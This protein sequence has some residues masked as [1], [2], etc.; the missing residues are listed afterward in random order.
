MSAFDSIRWVATAAIVSQLAFAQCGW[1]IQPGSYPGVEGTVR[2]SHLWDPDGSG[3]Q[4]GHLVIGGSL[5]FAGH[6]RVNGIAI[7]HEATRTWQPVGSAIPTASL[8]PQ[9]TVEALATMANGDLLVGGSFQTIDGVAVANVARFD[10]QAWTALGAGTGDAVYALTVLA[11]GNVVAGGE[12]SGAGTNAASGIAQWDGNSWS[13]LGAGLAWP[14]NQQEVRALAQLPNGDVIAGG[15]FTQAGAVPA[16]G[17]ARWDGNSWSG[18]GGGLNSA[19]LAIEVM[20]NGDMIVGGSF[21]SAGGVSARG[22]ARWDGTGWSALSTGLS[23]GGAVIGTVNGLATL[24]SGDLIAVGEFDTAGTAITPRSRVARWDGSQWAALGDGVPVGEVTTATVLAGGDLVIGGNFP[25]AGA[26][27]AISIARWDG[28]TWNA[29]SDGLNAAVHKLAVLPDGDLIAGGDFQM[30]GSGA[31]QRI[32]RWDGASWSPLGAGVDGRVNAIASLPNGDVVAGGYFQQAGSTSSDG[33]ARWDGSQWHSMLPGF[34]GGSVLG[35]LL[36]ANGQLVAVGSGQWGVRAWSGSNWPG[37]G[38][39]GGAGTVGQP[40]FYSVAELPN[41]DLVVGGNFSTVAGVAATCVARFDGSAWQPMG[42]GMSGM[43]ATVYC[44]AVAP[45]GSLVAGGSFTSAGGVPCDNIARWN[46]TSW[47]PIGN[48]L[49]G[50][51]VLDLDVLPN[52][53]V[54]ATGSL[55]AVGP[56]GAPRFARFNGNVWAMLAS[57]PFHT[58][59]IAR[60]PDGEIWLGG[61]RLNRL[62]PLCPATVADLGGGCVGG[63]GG[64]GLNQLVVTEP[65]WLGSTLRTRGSGL[66]SPSIAAIVYGFAPTFLPLASVLPQ[67]LAGC[68]LLATPDHVV[69]D[70]PVAGELDAA[71]TIPQS[72]ALVGVAVFEQ[73]V[74]FE[75]GPSSNLAAVSA[76]NALRLTVGSL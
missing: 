42:S 11:N 54:L 39:A 24:P 38:G 45:D 66:A 43:F 64:G 60:L 32:A 26:S 76:S 55:S 57:D 62:T 30:I 73:L 12:F 51:L 58:P 36:R 5:G 16:V 53:D 17:I 68:D 67:A 23:V 22:I 14:G 59:Q 49:P 44:F 52:G 34:L 50:A 46:G 21:G 18:I 70:V 37:L 27:H 4:P 13:A 1:H 10:G 3:P 71:L 47:S 65:A 48:G 40:T 33:I 31:A 6:A 15:W 7:Y 61:R 29:L 72:P 35:L 74:S 41:E 63:G 56:L 75:L 9:V 19:A 25:K 69:V 2:A 28:V 8:P 20:A